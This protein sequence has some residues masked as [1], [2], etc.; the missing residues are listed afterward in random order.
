MPDRDHAP[1]TP[2]PEGVHGGVHHH[3]QRVRFGD[4]DVMRHVNNVTYLRWYETGRIGLVTEVLNGGGT[5]PTA[6]SDGAEGGA[7]TVTFAEQRIAYRRPVWFG[8]DVDVLVGVGEVRRSSFAVPFRMLVGDE[9]A[10][11][12]EGWLVSFDHETQ[13]S[14]PL[15][16]E[17]RERLEAAAR[18]GAALLGREASAA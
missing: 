17:P 11:E 12:G 1:A 8:E 9:V 7:V 2:R 3:R 5:D 18:A 6:G 16:D 13:R 4:L 15:P 14:T 10:A